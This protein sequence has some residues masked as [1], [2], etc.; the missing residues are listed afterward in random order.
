MKSIGI[1]LADGSFY[2]IL[3]E[4][5]NETKDLEVTTVKDNQT[6]VQIDLYRSETNSM[7]DAEYVD[8]LEITHLKPHPNGEPTLS[9]EVNL[10]S[11]NKLHAQMKDPET[12]KS[13]EV[14]VHLVSRTEAERSEPV[15]FA[16][17]DSANDILPGISA[18]SSILGSPNDEEFSFDTSSE[19]SFNPS[20]DLEGASDFDDEDT[21]IDLTA[22]DIDSI[23]EAEVS[24]DFMTDSQVIDDNMVSDKPLTD[25]DML[26]PSDL[27]IDDNSYRDEPKKDVIVDN[28]GTGFSFV[29]DSEPEPTPEP[30]ADENDFQIPSSLLDPN[31]FDETRDPNAD[32]ANESSSV[33]TNIAPPDFSDLELDDVSD[34]DDSLDDQILAQPPLETELSDDD[35][36]HFDLPDFEELLAGSNDDF[37]NDETIEAEPTADET[38]EAEPEADETIE[39][40]PESAEIAAE[41]E[42][43]E[44]ADD[45]AAPSLELPDFDALMADDTT[46]PQIEASSETETDS[47]I[48]ANSETE[49]DSETETSAE[50]EPEAEPEEIEIDNEIAPDIPDSADE[51][52]DSET[53][54]ASF[55]LPDFDAMMADNDSDLDLEPKIEP[56]A[57]IETEANPDEEIDAEITAETDEAT[58]TE[59]EE[60]PFALPDFD[61]LTSDDDTATEID[62]NIEPEITE[63]EEP[64]PEVEADADIAPDFSLPSFDE[65]D[66]STAS[67]ADKSAF[68]SLVSTDVPEETVEEKIEP[69]E[70][71]SDD[72]SL[73]LPDFDEDIA[74]AGETETPKAEDDFSVDSLDLPDFG[75]I[76]LNS[77][78]ISEP[79]E[80]PNDDFSLDLPDFGEDG[81]A[82]TDSFGSTSTS[83]SA[84]TENEFGLPPLIDKNDF[85]ADKNSSSDTDTSF[86]ID[87]MDMPDFDNLDAT[88]APKTESSIPDD[89]PTFQ[90]PFDSL[91]SPTA[92]T[93]FSV[94]DFDTS[95]TD[96][97][98][99]S[100]SPTKDIFGDFDDTDAVF[101]GDTDGF[102][103]PTA[104]KKKKKKAKKNVQTYD[105]YGEKEEKDSKKPIIILLAALLACIVVILVLVL[106]SRGPKTNK[107]NGPELASNT[108]TEKTS[109][110]KI[111][112]A[113]KTPEI[114][115]SMGEPRTNTDEPE[116]SI[117]KDLENT[118][119]KADET[120]AQIEVTKP[121]VVGKAEKVE[122]TETKLPETASDSQPKTETQE[123]AKTDAQP[124]QETNTA[125]KTDAEEDVTVRRPKV[126]ETAKKVDPTA[127]VV[128]PARESTV[129][130]ESS[131]AKEVIPAKEDT[132]IVAS[133]SESIVPVKKETGTSSGPDIK[134]T[135]VWGDTLWDISTAYYKTPYRY[136]SIAE[137]NGISDAN[138]IRSGQVLLIP[139]E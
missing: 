5:S 12:G 111:E 77:D 10:D 27:F 25:S 113:K 30:K 101:E 82:D 66:S 116:I 99:L 123:A 71:A 85:I 41:P 34:I 126:F 91:S 9:L 122:K 59:S 29:D 48:E 42:T 106:Q 117:S 33:D 31:L 11:T 92:D 83:V 69:E 20:S 49:E 46:E 6:K 98:S 68:D 133:S 124:K 26:S 97:D 18:V 55:A 7:D 105:E 103:D 53:D 84:S 109:G 95:S 61:S 76:D 136:T 75:D 15:N 50:T 137:H 52:L 134:Y 32:S 67:E 60:N 110:G 96:D 72:L 138:K 119:S 4:G 45:I 89:F 88:S 94:P 120:A 107:N 87:D 81:T 135:V 70:N 22:L 54:D 132:I 128:V 17:N 44:I 74:S 80:K 62:S 73:D 40:E 79:E 90:D 1:K 35:S 58:E 115:T 114:V 57:E 104:G 93:D 37:E 102:V 78:K 23:E 121:D 36:E 108:G 38:I 127:Q 51:S 13:S 43:E 56:E 131:A 125:A 14:Q 139:A 39:A 63:S 21:T 130:K 65:L 118:A 2:P 129:A 86:S 16:L 3:E 28:D 100:D 24:D 64:E 19:L 112:E 8:S 47:D